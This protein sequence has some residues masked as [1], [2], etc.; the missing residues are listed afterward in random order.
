MAEWVEQKVM[1]RDFSV[2]HFSRKSMG[3]VGLQFTVFIVYNYKLTGGD[4][5]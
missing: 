2:Q 4:G 1:R 3:S 5:L